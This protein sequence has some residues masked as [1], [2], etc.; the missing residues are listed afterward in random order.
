MFNDY[1]KNKRHCLCIIFIIALLLSTMLCCF[2]ETMNQDNEM[3]EEI[4]LTENEFHQKYAIGLNNLVWNLLDKEEKTQ[5]DKDMMIHAAHTSLYHWSRIGTAINLQRG[6]WLISRVYA[7][8]NRPEA[9]V[10]HAENCLALTKEHGFLDF[11]LA[12]AY[13]AMARAYASAGNT[14]EFEKNFKLAREAGEK[15]AAEENRT[16]FFDD[17]NSEPWY[18]MK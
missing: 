15:I 16:L 8:L 11:D 12:Y 9:A 13:E 2:A 17:L 3:T 18:G 7:V 4:K 1:Q 6:E 14:T 5:Q 10:Y